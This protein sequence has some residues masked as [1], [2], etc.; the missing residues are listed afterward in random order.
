MNSE[1]QATDRQPDQPYVIPPVDVFENES[2]ITL[3]ADLPGVSKDRLNVRVDGDSLTL[4]ATA[5]TNVPQDMQLV[6]GE[7]Q[8]PSYRRQFTLSRELDSSHIEALLKDGVLRLTIPKLEEAKPR[9]IEV[10]VG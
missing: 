9:R 6:Y 7:A 8:Y 4:E 10:R 5:A 3:L 2:G 1:I